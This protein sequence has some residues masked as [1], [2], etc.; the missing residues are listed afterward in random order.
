M[1]DSGAD[2]TAVLA[3]LL[4]GNRSPDP[5]NPDCRRQAQ[6]GVLASLKG[7]VLA[8]TLTFRRDCVY[9]CHEWGCHLGLFGD[10]R[11]HG[12]RTALAAHGIAPPPRLELR[13]ECV[14][15]EGAVFFNFSRPD[16]SRRGWYAF[17]PVLAHRYEAVSAEAPAAEKPFD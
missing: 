12:L 16:S 15:E 13:L 10:K 2:I 17:A 11:W 8:V 5:A 3:E 14:V 6:Y 7:S 1:A 9:C 4:T